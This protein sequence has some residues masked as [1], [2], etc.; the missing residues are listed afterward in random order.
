MSRAFFKTKA[1]ILADEIRKEDNGKAII[2]GVYSGDILFPS[3]PAQ[4]KFGI[5]L[6]VEF[7][8]VKRPS[9]K[10]VDFRLKITGEAQP[11]CRPH[12]G[13]DASCGAGP[14]NLPAL[15]ATIPAACPLE[16]SQRVTGH[17]RVDD[18]NGGPRSLATTHGEETRRR[19][20]RRR[21]G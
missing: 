2:I 10:M 8:P 19:A 9:H 15:E 12:R 17:V 3:F 1:V 4:K 7:G 14:R 6:E 5:W 21:S 18:A 13:Q 11:F 16:Q 20:V